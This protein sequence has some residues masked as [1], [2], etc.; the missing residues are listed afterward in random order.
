MKIRVIVITIVIMVVLAVVLSS[1]MGRSSNAELKRTTI[2][3]AAE[4]PKAVVNSPETIKAATD[5]AQKASI[6]NMFVVESGRIALDESADEKI[7]KF[8]SMMAEHHSE[9]NQ[10]LRETI[11][12]SSVDKANLPNALDEKHS[13]RIEK[14]KA[15]KGAQFDNLYVAEQKAAH[16]EA[17]V[18]YRNYAASG[19]DRALKNYATKTLPMIEEHQKLLKGMEPK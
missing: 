1:M 13:L 5:F 14:L 19:E 6:G 8:A 15:A 9:A 4:S 17:V 3:E 7:K 16:D 2:I 18:L 10:N 12:S 11:D